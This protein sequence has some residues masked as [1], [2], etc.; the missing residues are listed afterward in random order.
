MR[1]LQLGQAFLLVTALATASGCRDRDDGTDAGCTPSGAEN[2]AATC[3]DN[4]DNDCNGFRDCNEFACCAV[5]TCDPSTT[6]GRRDGGTACT[7][8]G[9]EDSVAACSD[10]EDNDCSNFTDCED[11]DC[12]GWRN[13][14]PSGTACGDGPQRCETEAP[15]NTLAAC[16]DG[17]DNDGDLG[18]PIFE[19][20]EDRACC[21]IR[22]AGG[23]SCPSDSFCEER[24]DAMGTV[25]CAGDD[26]TMEA[27][28]ENTLARC[29]N[30][31]DDN[32]D[33]FQDCED[34]ACCLIR[35]EGG[36]ACAGTTYCATM[37][38]AGD[39]NLCAGDD[40]ADDPTTEDDATKCANSCDDDRDGFE[41]CEDR[42]CCVPLDA[43][44]VN[45]G[46]GTFCADFTP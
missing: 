41:D 9:P 26:V 16:M 18:D 33:G 2:S 3:S 39:V 19:D 12:C 17:C 35:E 32:R 45:C 6:C 13:D 31:C 1:T 42:D 4:I 23:V 15:E 40:V 11:F 43:A 14:C 8:T 10:G 38:Q 36:T 30:S 7:P 5:A 22:E 46:A 21:L 28:G 37:F 29:S 27:G 34:R 24:F 20:C 25:L 44:G